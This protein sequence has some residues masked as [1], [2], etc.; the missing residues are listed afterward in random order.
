MS[1]KTLYYILNLLNVPKFLHEFFVYK[2]CYGGNCLVVT[3]F[4]QKYKPNLFSLGKL[5][6]LMYGKSPRG[7]KFRLK[8]RG[9]FFPPKFAYG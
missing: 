8:I 1:E 6:L 2:P 9:V 5:L 7:I 3:S 4:V